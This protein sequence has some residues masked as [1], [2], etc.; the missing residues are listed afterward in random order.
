MLGRV[1]EICHISLFFEFIGFISEFVIN[2]YPRDLSYIPP[3]RDP[4]IW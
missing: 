4:V 1:L 2:D 3:F